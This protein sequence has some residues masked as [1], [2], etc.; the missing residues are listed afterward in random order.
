MTKTTT[1][2]IKDLLTEN[3]DLVKAL[4]SIMECK[5]LDTAKEIA[6]SA[7]GLDAGDIDDMSDDEVLD[8]FE[9]FETWN[10]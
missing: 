9:E 5:R 3:E 1:K 8:V 2:S 4:E 6:A 10:G 7:L